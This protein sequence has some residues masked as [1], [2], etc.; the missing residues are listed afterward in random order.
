[1]AT[2]GTPQP[3]GTVF[4]AAADASGMM[5]SFIQSNYYGFGSGVLVP[6]TGISMQNRAA[7]FSTDPTHPNAAAGGKRPFHTIIPGFLTQG[8]EPLAAVG[9]M[10]GPMQPQGH[11]QLATRL[12]DRGQIPQ[13]AI[14][15]PRWKVTGR[16]GVTCEAGIADE[17][18]SALRALGHDAT[19]S[20]PTDEFSFGGAQM[21]YRSD[22]GYIAASDPRKDG[23]A[24]GF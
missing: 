10:G 21:I 13:A 2:Y 9:V 18:V 11:L 14:D 24:A 23:Q 3:G 12:R 15:A 19:R 6:G 8:G 4:L 5:V 1:M 20:A 17:V 16:L 7:G 22:D